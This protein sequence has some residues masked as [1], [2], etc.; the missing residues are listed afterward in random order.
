MKIPQKIFK[1]IAISIT[2]LAISITAT[3]GIFVNPV[4]ANNGKHYEHDR[5]LN[6]VSKESSNPTSKPNPVQRAFVRKNVVHLTPEERTAFVNA[7][8]T[9][10][11]TIPE[12]STVSI[13]D[14]FVATHEGL[15]TFQPM[16]MQDDKGNLMPMLPTGVGPASEANPGHGND[17]FLPWHREFISRFEQVLQSVD[18]SV[19]LPYWDWTDPKALDVIFQPDFLGSR[20]EGTINI[21]GIGV[22]QGGPVGGNFSEANGWVLKKDINIDTL[23]HQ[24]GTALMR[25]LQT[26]PT[27]KYPLSKTDLDKILSYDSYDEYQYRL[28]GDGNP[29]N[30]N[31]YTKPSFRP[32]IEGNF[33]ENDQGNLK[34]GFYMHN[35]MHGLVGGQL[36]DGSLDPFGRP[37]ITGLLGTMNFAS[38]T[39]DPAFWL[40]HSNLDR[41]WAQW[42]ENGHTGTDFYPSEGQP[43]GHN[44]NDPMW[45]WDGGQSTP[46]L[47]ASVNL[48]PYLLSFAPEDIVTPRDTLD[49]KRY[50]YTYDTLTTSPELASS[51]DSLDIEATQNK[52]LSVRLISQPSQPVIKT[53]AQ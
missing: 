47:L 4:L 16:L 45:P 27:N 22:F 41:L 24:H 36:T 10:K 19:T 37:K 30:G 28:P 13:Y 8:H 21:P 26:P 6:Q 50:G 11:K 40:I 2:A 32:A 53:P 46:G 20:G 12:S 43:Y 52:V 17:A 5:L 3:L 44:L 34:P 38:V 1:T 42:Q 7:L 23:G 48:Q 14:Q 49:L 25:F 33:R 39:Y 29:H 31:F 15:M 35:Y 51:V 18:P 9:L